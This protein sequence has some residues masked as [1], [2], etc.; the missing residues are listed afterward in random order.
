MKQEKWCDSRARL[1]MCNNVIT[2]NVGCSDSLYAY[3]QNIIYNAQ[4]PELFNLFTKLLLYLNIC[5][6]I[7]F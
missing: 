1:N 7:I 5:N 2:T 3:K 6:L 4:A